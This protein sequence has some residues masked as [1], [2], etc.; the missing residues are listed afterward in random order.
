MEVASARA[1]IEL[2][3]NVLRYAELER[4]G[5]RYRLVRL[6]RHDFDTDLVDAIHHGTRA[7]HWKALAEVLGD[8][9][10]TPSA[11]RLTV[12]LHPPA[13]HSFFTALP[14]ALQGHERA[15]H[16]RR[17]VGVLMQS[18]T[19]RPLRLTADPVYTEEE[20]DETVEWL[21][22][23]A[24]EEEAQERIDLLVGALPFESYRLMLSTHAVASVVGHVERREGAGDRRGPYTLAVGWYPS[25]TEYVLCCDGQWRFG[26]HMDA[27]APEDTA[28]YAAALLQRLQVDPA[29]VGRLFTYGE[30]E[31]AEPFDPLAS[32]L[33]LTPEPLRPS[34]LVRLDADAVDLRV[35]A[36][37]LTP[38]VGAAL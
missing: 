35:D 21:H 37:S 10:D 27:L 2:C 5:A 12:T 24:L 6:G 23:L 29:A 33:R 32:A 1:S 38:C 26:R 19:P 31:A 16:L 20:G 22:V 25:H 8:L 7:E 15:Q 17:E 30:A 11:S 3:G 13:T 14:V 9:F 4:H 28:Y 34:Q 36:A 18:D